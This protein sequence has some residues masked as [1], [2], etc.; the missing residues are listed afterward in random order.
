MEEKEKLF[1]TVE[2]QLIGIDDMIKLESPLGSQHGNHGF[3]QGS[4]VDVGTSR[5][6]GAGKQAVYMVSKYIPTEFLLIQSG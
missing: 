3:R 1:P 5:R 4:S 2:C 6:E